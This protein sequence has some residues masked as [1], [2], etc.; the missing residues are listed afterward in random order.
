MAFPSIRSACWTFSYVSASTGWAVQG[1]GIQQT[2][3]FSTKDPCI[4]L[5]TCFSGQVVPPAAILLN[6]CVVL[7]LADGLAAGRDSGRERQR[8][9]VAGLVVW[10]ATVASLRV[11]QAA[12][13]GA[14][15]EDTQP[16]TIP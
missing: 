10:V 12:I 2:G 1:A 3:A 16:Q 6:V 13:P 14:N 5:I 4:T 11:E 15:N 7:W 9:L 8:D